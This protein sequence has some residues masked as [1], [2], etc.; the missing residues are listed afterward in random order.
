MSGKSYVVEYFSDPNRLRR[1]IKK[2]IK[3]SRDW[4]TGRLERDRV[5]RTLESRKGW[6]R[7]HSK[8]NVHR[9]KTRLETSHRPDIHFIKDLRK[10]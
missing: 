9:V 2:M 8:V 4:L 10:Y 7:I 5:M 6:N 1:F 3:D